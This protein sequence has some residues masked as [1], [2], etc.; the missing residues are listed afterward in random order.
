[1]QT[2]QINI[3]V[4]TSLLLKDYLD[5]SLDQDNPFPISNKYVCVIKTEEKNKI[6]EVKK[7]KIKI[8]ATSVEE[9]TFNIISE[10]A[11][12]DNPV[13]VYAFK[14][15]EGDK[16]LKPLSI[17]HSEIDTII[18]ESF[19]P[20]ATAIVNKDFWTCKSLVSDTGTGVYGISF[21]VFNDDLIVLGYFNLDITL[22]IG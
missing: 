12:F 16:I 3:I 1:M 11:N 10:S 7:S 9:I 17:W 21:A 2:V 15:A 8:K 18:P 14:S 4:F 13:L 6:R 20:L 22:S 19:N 5:P